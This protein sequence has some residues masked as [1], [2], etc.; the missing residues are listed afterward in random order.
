MNLVLPSQFHNTLMNIEIFLL[1]SL[2]E[3]RQWKM[4][5]LKLHKNPTFCLEENIYRT[6]DATQVEFCTEL[7]T[8]CIFVAKMGREFFNPLIQPGT[9]PTRV[10]QGPTNLTMNMWMRHP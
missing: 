7:K 4:I 3:M 1:L 5:G 8:T 6:G 9:S 2:K 10:G